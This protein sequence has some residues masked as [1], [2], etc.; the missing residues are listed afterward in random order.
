MTPVPRVA[1]F[2]DS[3]HEV[4]GVALTSRQ[5]EGF[6]RRQSL[7]FLSVHCGPKDFFLN[8]EPVWTLELRRG[9]AAFGL[10]RD[11]SCDPLLLCRRERVAQVVS[12]FKPDLIHITGPGDV[13]ILGAWTAHSLRVPLAASWHTNLHEFAA[14]RLE[15]SLMG[16][17]R[18]IRRTITGGVESAALHCVLQFYRLARLLFAPNPELVE[19][20]QQ[21]TGRPT[22]LM[23]RGID[24]ALFS[25]V[26]RDSSSNSLTLGFVGRLSPEKNVR[27]LAQ[28]ER[29]LLNAGRCDFRFL[30]V[31]GG[32]EKQWLSEHLWHA[33]FPGV[34]SGEAL[35][36][37]YAN[38]DI[39]VFPSQTDTF[40]NV[41]LE[42][43]ASG[44]PAVVT[45][46][47]GPKFLVASGE[48]GFVASDEAGLLDCVLRLADDPGL[49]RDMGNVARRHALHQSWDQIFENVY[50]AYGTLLEGRSGDTWNSKQPSDYATSMAGC[51]AS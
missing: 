2:T 36:R 27:F 20:L 4:N 3:F 15:R 14:R 6:A 11:L 1:F 21:R 23:R 49:R 24:T 48:T 28:I 25:P 34:L 10:E 50:S 29:A 39:F 16:L 13:G 42:A 35:A 19:L 22:C 44:V 8:Q 43:M 41:I 26:R 33:E 51:R 31:G 5:F 47:G 7:P 18:Q 46:D 9:R 17:P 37:A 12:E 30:I 45:A 40:G 38:M 32:S